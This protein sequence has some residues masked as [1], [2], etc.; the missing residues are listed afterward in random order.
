MALMLVKIYNCMFFDEHQLKLIFGIL[1]YK[2]ICIL[3][4]PSNTNSLYFH[5]IVCKAV[6]FIILLFFF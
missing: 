6:Y 1:I 2:Y 4:F 3:I 5:I